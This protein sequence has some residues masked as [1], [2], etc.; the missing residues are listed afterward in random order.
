[1]H[2]QSP[3]VM[4]GGIVLKASNDHDIL[5]VTFDPK[6]TFEVPEQPLKGLLNLG[7][8]GEYSMTNFFLRDS[9]G[10]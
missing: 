8:S 5:G 4:I 1:M 6:M 10:I 7:S 9:F 2:P 3:T